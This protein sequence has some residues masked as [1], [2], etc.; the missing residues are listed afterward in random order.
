MIY[1]SLYLSKMGK[2]VSK[3]I[4]DFVSGFEKTSTQRIYRGH[5]NT[6][7]KNISLETGVLTRFYGH[8]INQ[9]FI[10]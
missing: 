6:F 4:E 10:F 9:L 2:P 5:L 3:V 8:L 1:I 7:F